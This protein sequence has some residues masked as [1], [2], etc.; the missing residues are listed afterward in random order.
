MVTGQIGA[1]VVPLLGWQVMFLIG[2]IPGLV[3][4]GLLLRLRRLLR[5]LLRL[6]LG[7]LLLGLR[8]LADISENRL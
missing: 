1:L 5:V 4:A 2:G 3:I 6:L 7:L 8:L